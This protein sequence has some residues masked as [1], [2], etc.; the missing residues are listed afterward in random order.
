MAVAHAPSTTQPGAA[1]GIA[2]DSNSST[3]RPSSIDYGQVWRIQLDGDGQPVPLASQE[4]YPIGIAV[5]S[6]SVY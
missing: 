1:V 3:G 6:S 5:D 2:V 4:V